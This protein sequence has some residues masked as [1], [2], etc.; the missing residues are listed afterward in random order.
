MFSSMAFVYEQNILKTHYKINKH[1]DELF[2]CTTPFTSYQDRL[3]S[4]E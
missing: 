4:R 1:V 3:I 2:Y